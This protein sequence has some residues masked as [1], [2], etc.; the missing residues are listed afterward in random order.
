M[1]RTRARI[2]AFN[3][4]DIVDELAV[5]LGKRIKAGRLTEE[6]LIHINADAQTSVTQVMLEIR[7]A[8]LKGKKVVLNGVGTIYPNTRVFGYGTEEEK[9]ITELR[10]IASDKLK[11]EIRDVDIDWLYV[12]DVVG[13]TKPEETV[14]VDGIAVT[15]IGL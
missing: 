2:T 6:Q 3:T 15:N 1:S 4:S 7:G 10:F 9:R 12:D 13:Q 5:K 8:L 11:D 14:I